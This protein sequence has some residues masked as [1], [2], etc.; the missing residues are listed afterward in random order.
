[1]REQSNVFDDLLPEQRWQ[2]RCGPK[3]PPS[4]PPA[5]PPIIISPFSYQSPAP[6]IDPLHAPP[7]PPVAP[8]P[9]PRQRLQA[10]AAKPAHQLRAI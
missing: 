8:L 6:A 4:A 3:N 1:M 9:G 10:C 5:I 2:A 7:R